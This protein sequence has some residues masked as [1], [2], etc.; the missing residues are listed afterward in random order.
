MKFE[1]PSGK[2]ELYSS[3]AEEK[4]GVNPL[5][6]YKS[7]DTINMDDSF[8]LVF[9]TPNTGSRIHS[10]F[11]NLKIIRESVQEQPAV[12]ISPADARIR[13]ISSDDKI[14]VFNQTGEI[15]SKVQISNRI[16]AGSIV[17]PNGIWFKEGGGGNHLIE[18]RETDMGHGSAFHDN[19]V[20]I[21]RVD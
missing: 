13:N 2:V 17:L 15:I 6:D 5:P 11:G 9:I 20:E 3:E 1:T 7:L 21:E 16:T 8:P 18:G 4:W 14:R 19:R 10:Q 12:A